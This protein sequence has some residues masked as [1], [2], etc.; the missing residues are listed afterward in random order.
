VLRRAV[1]TGA[2]ASGRYGNGNAWIGEGAKVL[3]FEVTF[4]RRGAWKLSAVLLYE[5]RSMQH[6]GNMVDLI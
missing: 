2:S 1:A 3:W 5:R 4:E 6:F